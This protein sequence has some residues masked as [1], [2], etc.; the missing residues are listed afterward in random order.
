M[1]I[2]I[3]TGEYPP[4]QGG[5]GAYT[6]ILATE[7]ARQGH[8][9]FVFS[10]TE[11]RNKNLA[12]ALTN[13]IEK[14]D[15][16]SLRAVKHWA[17]ALDV[18]VINLQFQTAAFGMSGWIH[19]LPNI[20]GKI[21]CVTTFHDLRFP[22]LFPKAGKLRDWIVMHLARASKGVI[23][24]NHEDYARL[25]HLKKSALIPIGSNILQAANSHD[26]EKAWQTAQTGDFKIAYFGLLNRSKGLDVLLEA[27]AQLRTEGI[28]AR[29]AL[30]GAGAGSS[31]PTNAAF[32]QELEQ[33]ITTLK[34]KEFVYQTGFLEDGAVTAYLTQSD[35]VAL[36][37]IDGASYR[38]GSLM[39]AIHSGCAIVT[40]QPQVDIPAFRNGDNMRLVEAGNIEAL[41]DALRELYEKPGLRGKFRQGAEKLASEFEWSQIAEKCVAFFE[42]VTS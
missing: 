41:T 11:A 37:F 26:I 12:L 10:T 21:P 39:A 6:Q 7:L 35:V 27:V 28:P 42:Q 13:P 2:G 31:D 17:E 9:V 1:L 25:K 40:T 19:F 16:A 38:R 29:L 24:T 8:T 18:D 22:Y 15:F 34:L 36:P 14:W 3:V 4:M 33:Q 32:I 23:A 20:L 30:V 5:V